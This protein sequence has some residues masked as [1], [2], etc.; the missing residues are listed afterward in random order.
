MKKH[1]LGGG[2][3][4]IMTRK[5]IADSKKPEIMK[6]HSNH[7]HIAMKQKKIP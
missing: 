2:V 6:I 1:E 4:E 7:E 5:M 3:A